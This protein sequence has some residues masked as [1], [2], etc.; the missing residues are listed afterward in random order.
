MR[1]VLNGIAGVPPIM[2]E[3]KSGHIINCASV[4][5]YR[6]DPTAAVYCATKYAVRA[7]SEGLRQES[8]ELRVTIVSP[9][10]TRT[11]PFDG[12]GA[13]EARAFAKGMVERPRSRP[14]PSPKRSASPSASP[15]MS[16]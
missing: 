1:G 16:T 10:L 13:P 14:A 6:V 7:L 2:G 3:Q 9:G 8:K 15:R 12:I 11:E 4:S 5:A